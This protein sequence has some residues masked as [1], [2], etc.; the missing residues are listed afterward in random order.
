[1]KTSGGLRSR[2]GGLAAVSPVPAPL[3]KTEGLLKELPAERNM[4]R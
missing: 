4:R 2:D 3:G 1:M